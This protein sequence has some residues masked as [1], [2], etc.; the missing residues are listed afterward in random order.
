MAPVAR[1]VRELGGMPFLTDANTLY[2]GRRHNAYDHVRAALENG[3]SR[4]ATGCDILIADGLRGNDYL[5][6]PVEGGK[7]CSF[8][9]IASAVVRG[10]SCFHVNFVMNV[11]PNCDCWAH[12]DAPI[13]ADI[14]IFA[15]PDPVALDQACVDAVYAAPATG[16]TVLTDKSNPGAGEK[17]GHI[18]PDTDWSATLDHCVRMGLG[19]R[20]GGT[21][22]PG[23]LLG[24]AG[25]RAAPQHQPGRVGG[26]E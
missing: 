20:Q 21:E 10:K 2:S 23:R 16:G 3:F 9:M 18:H 5:S 8:A 11:S 6:V 19:G 12:N 15:S 13:V 4:D 17:F 24:P 26:Q 25:S 7:H 1:L 14:G 22:G